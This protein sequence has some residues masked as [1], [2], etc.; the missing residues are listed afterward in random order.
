[1]CAISAWLDEYYGFYGVLKIVNNRIFFLHKK[2]YLK[3]C[4]ALK[5]LTK[6]N[7]NYVFAWKCPKIRFS[8]YFH[9][10]KTIYYKK[11]FSVRL[12]YIYGT[13]RCKIH[14]IDIDCILGFLNF[15]HHLTPFSTSTFNF[16]SIVCNF[17]SIGRI[18]RILWGFEN[19]K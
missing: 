12:S 4:T 14:H 19:C 8:H 17:S 11:S 1:M 10:K 13:D 15:F 16:W 6:H 2:L 5:G 3:K 18:L 7:K 9:N